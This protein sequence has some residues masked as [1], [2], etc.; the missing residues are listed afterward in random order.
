MHVIREPPIQ[1][2]H[3]HITEINT[4][5]IRK[6]VTKM[7]TNK[8]YSNRFYII[9]QNTKSFKWTPQTRELKQKSAEKI[10]I[11]KIVVEM[12]LLRL[13]GKDNLYSLIC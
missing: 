10:H 5:P 11:R 1:I 8:K 12:I 9:Y 4:D 7:R 2:R 3:N 6:M 13:Q